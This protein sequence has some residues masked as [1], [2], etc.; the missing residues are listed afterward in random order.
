MRMQK[1]FFNTLTEKRNLQYE[2]P[3]FS[4]FLDEFLVN[5][6]SIRPGL[7]YIT[8]INTNI[9]GSEFLNRW[10]SDDIIFFLI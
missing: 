4:L 6:D 7:C 9:P 5:L 10:L 1:F 3:T 2:N 8:S